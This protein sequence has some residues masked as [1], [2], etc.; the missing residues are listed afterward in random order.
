ME[1]WV[2]QPAGKCY[3]EEPLDLRFVVV[4]TPVETVD[5]W[6][7]ASPS[8]PEPVEKLCIVV[9]GADR[10]VWANPL[11]FCGSTGR[12]KLSSA[13]FLLFDQ[14]STELSTPVNTTA[15]VR[16]LSGDV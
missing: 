10:G 14:L 5:K 9:R 4:V 2:G 12:E 6:L 16:R 8:A 13:E 7:T 3:L 1:G 15:V 11:L